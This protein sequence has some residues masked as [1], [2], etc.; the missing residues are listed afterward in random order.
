MGEAMADG[1]MPQGLDPFNASSL[2]VVDQYADGQQNVL[3]LY[4]DHRTYF[5]HW[6]GSQNGQH[7]TADTAYGS[8]YE[9][10]VAIAPTTIPLPAD[11]AQVFDTLNQLTVKIADLSASVVQD[12]AAVEIWA[13]R[14]QKVADV[15][16]LLGA[17]PFIGTGVS[18]I[19]V[20][21]HAA[22]VATE[23]VAAKV[24]QVGWSGLETAFHLDDW[25][26]WV[27]QHRTV[28][29]ECRQAIEYAGH[30]LSALGHALLEAVRP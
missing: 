18:A 5:L 1:T 21:L 9:C 19:G 4:S 17:I 20:A 14:V 10:Y 26:T 15:L 11:V 29:D 12:S 24:M 16:V 8:A 13:E 22:T 25:S 2:Q 30:V 23:D 28:S 3:Y 7:T 6:A 27:W